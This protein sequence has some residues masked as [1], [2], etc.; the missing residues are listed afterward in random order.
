MRWQIPILSCLLTLVLSGMA[1]GRQ[2]QSSPDAASSPGKEK[3]GAPSSDQQS[4]EPRLDPDTELRATVQQSMGDNAKLLQN[5][6]AYL[7][8]YPQTPRRVA[9]YRGMMQAAMQMNDP[10]AALEFADKAIAIE[11]DDS[12]TLYLAVTTLQKLPDDDSQKR[13]IDYDT[14]LI[15]VIAKANPETRPPQMSLEEWQA[16]RNKFTNELYVIR[17]RIERKLHQDDQAIKDLNIAFRLVPSSDAAVAL[18]EIAEQDKHTDEAVREYALALILSGQDQDADASARNILLHRMT[19]LWHFT[20]D[21]DA[22]LGDIF[23]SA[24]NR[25]LE[26][27]QESSLVDKPAPPEYNKGATDPLQF[28]LR[29]IDGNGAV[30]LADTRGK[31]VILNFW[32]TWCAYCQTLEPMLAEVRTKFAGRDDVE[33][34]AVNADENE[35]LVAPFLQAQK[36][37]GTLLFADGLGPSLHVASIPTII[38][39]DRAGKIAYRTQGYVPDGFVDAITAAITKSVG[40]K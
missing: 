34:F 18:G 20:H 11:P 8:K 30:K 3:S 24:F 26:M 40:V 38:V 33:S 16:G 39:L 21:S 29:Q 22:G 19:N 25:N 37:G 28:S 10:K 14:R 32:T 27:V 31:V 36:V 15:G 4:P 35:A 2:P 9:I 5:L 6:Q 23:L 7:D 12:Q 1:S 13:A 17:G